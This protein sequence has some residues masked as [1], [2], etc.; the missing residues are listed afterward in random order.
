MIDR[1]AS[2]G[3]VALSLTLAA[4]TSPIDALLDE[5]VAWHGE[6]VTYHA[7]PSAEVCAGTPWHVDGFAPFVARELG[8]SAPTGTHYLWLN[9]EQLDR[10]SDCTP[11][12]CAY[13]EFAIAR[14]PSL[15]HEVV[16]V[17]TRDS[18]M[19]RWEFFTEGIAWAYDAPSPR[20]V[21]SLN[22]EEPLPDPRPMMLLDDPSDIHY[23][24]AGSFV[25]LLLAR[26]GP[27]PFVEFA[28]QLPESRTIA[29][30]EATFRRVYGSELAV[31]V[32]LFMHGSTCTDDMF[33]VVP[34]DCAMPEVAW[35]DGRQWLYTNV[36]DCSS[37]DVVGGVDDEVWP[38][39]RSV[40]MDVPASGA[41]QL[42]LESDGEVR[43]EIGPCFGCPWQ[44]RYHVLTP[45][46]TFTVDLEAGPHYVRMV[47][48]SDESPTLTL[49]VQPNP[50]AEP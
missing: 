8:I 1:N 45:G 15:V 2:G 22:P 38:S 33:D 37:G 3:L 35:I 44:P 27:G 30:L 12:G 49:A 42:S 32:D 11:L 25:T 18:G 9:P 21:V 4:C 7:N 26:H 50:L 39:A 6:Y 41:H 24:I 14:P 19:N 31:E 17:V 47:G 29:D 36:M 43:V 40:T 5:M 46:D 10:I 16:H 34:Y 28:R 48:Q 23:G 20:Y 13:D